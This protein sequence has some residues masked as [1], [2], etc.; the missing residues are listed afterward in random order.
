[1]ILRIRL[2]IGFPV[3]FMCQTGTIIKIKI[4]EKKLGS[5]ANYSLTDS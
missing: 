5:R 4:F 3:L 1:M 2:G